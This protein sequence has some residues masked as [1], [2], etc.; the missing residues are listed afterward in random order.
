[1]AWHRFHQNI[2]ASCSDDRLLMIWDHREKSNGPKGEKKP[3]FEIV[4]HTNEIYSLDFSPFNEFLLLSG[5]A[6][7]T[8]S[9]WDMRNLTRS[10]STIQ[11]PTVN[12]ERGSIIKA[13]WSPFTSTIF[14]TCGYGRKVDIWDLSKEN[15]QSQNQ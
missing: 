11:S 15:L 5:S 12:G 3:I 9:V 10:L 13:Q 14:A 8:A 4:A 1:V 6:D 2:F 7:E